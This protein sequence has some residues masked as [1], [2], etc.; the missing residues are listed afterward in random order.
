VLGR[1]RAEGAILGGQC[2]VQKKCFCVLR[3]KEILLKHIK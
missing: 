2:C 1:K 3:R